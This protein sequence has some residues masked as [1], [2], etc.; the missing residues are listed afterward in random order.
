MA[1]HMYLVY[2]IAGQLVAAGRQAKIDEFESTFA[3]GDDIVGLDV[4]VVEPRLVELT[5]QLLALGSE[6]TELSVGVVYRGQ[7]SYL[8][9]EF[10][11]CNGSP[12]CDMMMNRSS[13]PST[14]PLP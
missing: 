1:A 13:D 10:H 8:V 9:S 2:D 4:M 6:P 3:V 12:S 14:C 11:S 5:K 7:T